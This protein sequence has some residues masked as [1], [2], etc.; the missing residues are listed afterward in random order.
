VRNASSRV[1][2]NIASNRRL[3]VLTVRGVASPDECSAD[4]GVGVCGRLI[5]AMRV[6]TNS[7]I[8]VGLYG[9]IPVFSNAA[10]M[11]DEVRACRLNHS[12]SL[13]NSSLL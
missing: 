10:L 9:Q 1:L 4:A 8:G 13:K 7:M 3:S 12:K 11:V 6:R 2:S 5:A